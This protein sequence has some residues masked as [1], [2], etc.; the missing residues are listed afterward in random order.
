MHVSKRGKY[1]IH[2]YVRI[3][4]RTWVGVLNGASFD[5]DR[6]PCQSGAIC[7]A[8]LFFIFDATL[9]RGDSLSAVNRGKTPS[10]STVLFAS[11]LVFVVGHL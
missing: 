3:Q 2:V 9:L 10:S 1:R 8:S 6:R 7:V 5:N 11:A 4:A